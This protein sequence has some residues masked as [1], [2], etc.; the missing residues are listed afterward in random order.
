MTNDTGNA[1]AE[2][3]RGPHQ[4]GDIV[5]GNRDVALEDELID[6]RVIT[7]E[8]HLTLHQ[9]M[10][11]LLIQCWTFSTMVF[12]VVILIQP[13]AAWPPRSPWLRPSPESRISPFS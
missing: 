2:G 8:G 1:L 4:R 9:V 10:D 7:F 13:R 11:Q 3:V 5:L 12:L 6:R